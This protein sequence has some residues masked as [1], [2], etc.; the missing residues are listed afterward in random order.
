MKIAFYTNLVH[1][2]WSAD[3]L[4]TGVGGSEEVLILL[5]RELVK[6]G[7]QVTIFHN[8]KHGEFDGVKYEDHRQFSNFEGYDVFVAFKAP[9]ILRET[10]NAKRK[11]Y[12]SVSSENLPIW[13]VEASEK[14]IGIS[15]Y[16]LSKITPSDADKKRFYLFA[17]EKEL[18]EAKDDRNSGTILY[19][20]SFDRGLED[21]LKDWSEIRRNNT[22]INELRI[23]YGWDFMDK[24]GAGSPDYAKWKNN[25]LELMRQPGITYLG[26]LSRGDINREYWRAEYWA[27]PLNNPDSELFC[28]NAIKAQYCGAKPI[29]NK[30]GALVET[31]NQY[32]D[33]K[34]F[35]MGTSIDPNILANKQYTVGFLL[36]DAI[37]RWLGIVG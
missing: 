26:R 34:E 23:A 4:E 10:I 37:E 21:L 22:D 32:V 25:M 13:V 8:G 15:D 6:K 27:L 3:S 1:E 12:F 16:H 19:S 28:I 9:H 24:G 7:H 30:E 11:F 33:Y 31:V 14:I 5:S 17:D 18:V 36:E 2:G 20:S 29:V 35:V